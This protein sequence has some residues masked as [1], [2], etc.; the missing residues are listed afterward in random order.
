[1][2]LGTLPASVYMRMSALKYSDGDVKYS[3]E[4]PT[5]QAGSPPPIHAHTSHVLS[6]STEPGGRA[7]ASL[8]SLKRRNGMCMR[9]G[10]MILAENGIYQMT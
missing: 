4:V 5:R 7:S 1:M 2:D 10:E 9:Q 3:Y 8:A 6:V